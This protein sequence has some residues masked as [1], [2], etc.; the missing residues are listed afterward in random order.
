MPVQADEGAVI[1]AVHPGSG[2]LDEIVG[3][4]RRLADEHEVPVVFVMVVARQP[5]GDELERMRERLRRYGRSCH[6]VATWIASEGLTSRDRDE[7]VGRE[8][9]ATAERLA[10]EV[11]VVGHGPAPHGAPSR[12]VSTLAARLADS[13]ELCIA[14]PPGVASP[15]DD[16]VRTRGDDSW[17]A[18][19]KAA[20]AGRSTPAARC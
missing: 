12:V 14:P 16:A 13:T 4:A 8:L 6:L 9:A 11:I 5:R 20:G 17:S 3:R 18:S 10:A 15:F 2:R 19:S 1:A 7:L